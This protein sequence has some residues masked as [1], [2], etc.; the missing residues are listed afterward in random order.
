[1]L[2]FLQI[3]EKLE[4]RDIR[5][6][7]TRKL[8]L[9]CGDDMTVR[10]YYQKED[11]VNATTIIPS[12]TVLTDPKDFPTITE[13]NKTEDT[14]RIPAG[15]SGSSDDEKTDGE[16]KSDN[17]PSVPTRHKRK[18]F[19]TEKALEFEASLKQKSPE[20]EDEIEIDEP[21]SKRKSS[22]PKKVVKKWWE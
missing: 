11:D 22:K 7:P 14:Q 3:T 20:D 9:T 17:S 21:K 5:F 2:V 4:I 10:I 6:H 1:V 13:P 19:K 15:L 18:I 8:L 16:E 12:S